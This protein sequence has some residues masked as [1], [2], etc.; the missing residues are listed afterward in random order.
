M[1]SNSIL[2]I[3]DH[4][5]RDFPSLSLIGYHL[6]KLGYNIYYCGTSMENEIF[7][8]SNPKFIIIPKLTYHTPNQLKWKLEGRK[9]IIIETEGNNQDKSI[10]YRVE[11]FPDL[12]FFWN[13]HVKSLYEKEL[14]YNNT[15][16]LVKGYYRSDYYFKPLN[17]I[18][19]P[20]KIKATLGINNK[21]KIVTIA[22]STQD[23]H[24][25]EKRVEQKVKIRKNNFSLTA[26]YRLIIRNMRKLRKITEQFLID[27]KELF[28]E[29]INFV[30]KPHPNESVIYWNKLIEKN[31]LKNCYLMVGK[32]INELLAISDFHISHN[33]CTTTAEAMMC[34]LATLE[35]NTKYSK[36]LYLEDHLGLPDYR[37]FSSQEVIKVLNREILKPTAISHSNKIESYVKEYFTLFDGK[38]CEDYA[39]S[40][41]NFINN[42]QKAPQRLSVKL[43]LKYYFLISII[44]IKYIIKKLLFGLK[45][46]RKLVMQVNRPERFKDGKE[47][48]EI[49][50]QKVHKDWGLFD[51]KI[52]LDDY[53][54]WYK[55]FSKIGI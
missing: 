23:S 49:N 54:Y 48:Y 43:K 7:E 41:D 24:F 30:I 17:Q 13:N 4:K 53:K 37:A 5:H 51:N 39:Y 29:E 10:K 34:N 47:F 16:I 26:D 22:T 45:D 6:E 15:K 21:K 31:N 46:E 9:I 36:D 11:V 44:K 1:N 25:S 42:D 35:I 33:V 19:N 3:V 2:F 27:Q 14:L 52:K 8:K 40:I 12:Y 38:R 50:D 18:F 55:Q 28:N 20:D 32:N